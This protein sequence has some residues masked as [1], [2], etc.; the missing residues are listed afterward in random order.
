MSNVFLSALLG[1]FAAEVLISISQNEVWF[2]VKGAKVQRWRIS[3]PLQSYLFTSYLTGSVF[4]TLKL[5]S[6]QVL[7]P[8]SEDAA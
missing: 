3:S 6:S 2:S 8:W 7:Q 5:W 4:Y 1:C